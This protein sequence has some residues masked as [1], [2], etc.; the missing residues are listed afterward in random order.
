MQNLFIKFKAIIPVLIIISFTINANDSNSFDNQ[1]PNNISDTNWSSLKIAAHEAKLLPTPES[2]GGEDSKFGDSVSIDGNRAL[3]GSPYTQNHG[4]AYI[5]DFDGTNWIETS[6]LIPTDKRSGGKF[7]LSVKLFGDR[8]IVGSPHNNENGDYSGAVYIYDL[9]AGIWVESKVMPSDA[10]SGDVFGISVSQS[11]N[12]ILIGAT[13]DDDNGSAS[14]SV[15]IFEKINN[16]WVEVQKLIASDG[17]DEDSFGISVSVSG[18]RVLVGSYKNDELSPGAGAAYIFE[19]IGDSWIETKLTASDGAFQDSFGYSV[20][21][22]GDRALISAKG[23]DGLSNFSGSAYIFEFVKGNWLEK[24]KLIASDGVNSLSFGS[25]VSLLD[26][27]LV[28][29]AYRHNANGTGAGAAYVYELTEGNWGESII[30]SSDNE[31]Y[32]QFGESVSISNNRVIVGSFGDDDFGDSS[33]AAYVF[34]LLD[35]NWVETQKITASEG[36]AKDEFGWSISASGNRVL[37]G[38]HKD[39]DNELGSGSAYIFE[40]V[41]GNWVASKLTASDRRPYDAFGFSVSL[42]DNKALVGAYHSN[43]GASGSV[44]YFEL[45]KGNWIEVQKLTASDGSPLDNFGSSVNLSGNKAIIGSPATFNQNKP[46]SAYIFDLI[47]N[48]WVE[49]QKLTASNGRVKDF[50]GFSTSLSGERALIGAHN[51]GENGTDIG[52]AYIFDLIEGTWV[53]TQTLIPSDGEVKDGFGYSVG[54][55]GDKV[56]VGAYRGK[57]ENNIITGSVYLFELI[58]GE[59]LET[60][61]FASDG[62]IG[63]RFGFSLD[64]SEDRILIGAHDDS[65]YGAYSGS[66]YFYELINGGWVETKLTQIDGSYYDRFGISVGLSENRLFVGSFLDDDR[67]TDSGSVYIFNTDIIFINGFE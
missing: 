13:G 40:L 63:D 46:G 66:A 56:L 64:I 59:W 8:A 19:L 5:F 42:D 14:G 22:S 35:N 65:I 45:I 67:G 47:G 37:I 52:S 7:G 36:A 24:T 29:G 23:D 50:F 25:S 1:R 16:N 31:S 60:K 12:R 9:I 57:N 2:I 28:I 61:I 32:D 58:N 26:N 41:S 33:G 4:V 44:Y 55:S 38:A 21:L 17:F 48:E 30:I 51:N 3:I 53:E 15:Y 43:G 27:T 20:S 18:N 54:L 10:S 62:T 34:D 39:D 49:S 6:I 11:S